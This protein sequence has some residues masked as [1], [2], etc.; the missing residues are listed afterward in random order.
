MFR[1]GTYVE[2]L[3]HEVEKLPILISVA[4]KTEDE[5]HAARKRAYLARQASARAGR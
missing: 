1:N 2:T 5:F 4:G 3:D